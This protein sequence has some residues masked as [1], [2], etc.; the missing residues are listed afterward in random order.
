MILTIFKKAEALVRNGNKF[1]H[2]SVR[3]AEVGDGLLDELSAGGAPLDFWL[4]R[5]HHHFLA[6]L[7]PLPLAHCIYI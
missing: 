3:M 1:F 7:R 5:R 4:L 2:S 6:Q